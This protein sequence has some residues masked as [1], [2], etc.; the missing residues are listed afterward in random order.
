ME[1]KFTKGPWRVFGDWGIQAKN[2]VSCLATFEFT[3]L[4]DGT[5]NGFDNAHLIAAAPDM[6]K[7]LQKFLPMDEDGNGWDF[8]YIE[9]SEHL[10]E[11][12][13]KLLAKARGE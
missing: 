12:V 6:Y 9:G 13:V 11:Q 5:S 8:Q 2:E 7:L 1:A 3:R 10:G 4:D